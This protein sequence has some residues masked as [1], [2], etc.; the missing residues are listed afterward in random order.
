MGT[1]RSTGEY[2]LSMKMISQLNNYANGTLREDWTI[3]MTMTI[4]SIEK[5][6]SHGFLI[7]LCEKATNIESV[8]VNGY[9]ED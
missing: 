5:M 2:H 1:P 4:F 9:W 3:L 6:Y 8:G 7:F